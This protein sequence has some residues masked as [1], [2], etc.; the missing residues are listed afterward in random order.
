MAALRHMSGAP[1]TVDAI[2]LLRDFNAGEPRR[3]LR[4]QA[5]AVLARMRGEL[6]DRQGD[7]G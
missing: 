5:K 1:A 2:T 4:N 6:R 7:G 3:L